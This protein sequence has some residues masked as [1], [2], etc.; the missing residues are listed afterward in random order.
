MMLPPLVDELMWLSGD[1]EADVSVQCRGCD[2]GGEPVV[3]YTAHG[4]N[5]YD[6]ARVPTARTIGELFQLMIRHVVDVHDSP[7]LRPMKV[8]LVGQ[9]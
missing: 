6:E 7:P 5:P 1:E 3:F 4:G 9:S 2:K 8:R